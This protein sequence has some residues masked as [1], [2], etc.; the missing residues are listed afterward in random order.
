MPSDYTAQKMDNR[1]PIESMFPAAQPPA[2]LSPPP[3]TGPVENVGTSLDGNNPNQASVMA[4]PDVAPPPAP[5][6]PSFG[7]VTPPVEPTEERDGDAFLDQLLAGQAGS[8]SQNPPPASPAPEP[9]PADVLPAT[10]PTPEP[11]A[12]SSIPPPADF[13]GAAET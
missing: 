4:P 9:P 3:V 8:G 6:S 12:S 5:P 10:P 1:A 11:S 13:P 2:P 7:A